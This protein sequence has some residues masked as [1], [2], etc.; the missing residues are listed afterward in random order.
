MGSGRLKIKVG[1]GSQGDPRMWREKKKTTAKCWG[2]SWRRH[3]SLC[4]C[5]QN[6]R[7]GSPT[8]AGGRHQQRNYNF[9]VE[10]FKG[11]GT[12]ENN[13]LTVI[14]S[15]LTARLHWDKTTDDSSLNYSAS[16]HRHYLRPNKI[17]F[18]LKFH[19]CPFEF[20][21]TV[22]LCF[23][24][25]SLFLC[26]L[27]LTASGLGTHL[28]TFSQY[29]V[30]QKENMTWHMKVILSSGSG[31]QGPAQHLN[32]ICTVPTSRRRFRWQQKI[33][34]SAHHIKY[35]WPIAYTPNF[36]PICQRSP[37]EHFIKRLAVKR[38]SYRSYKIFICL[39]SNVVL[40][41]QFCD[42]TQDLTI[43]KNDSAR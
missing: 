29:S 1:E 35:M 7:A 42:S 38:G 11:L 28:H 18:S 43:A 25:L 27:T 14:H 41:A 33:H 4:S 26:S 40:I 16:C 36:V 37:N 30:A 32:G 39:S 13:R 31:P 6:Q 3:S 21:V 8:S 15:A 2:S 24:C 9:K 12:L 17:C 23:Y 10:H 34:F 22:Q 19:S 20:T 5:I